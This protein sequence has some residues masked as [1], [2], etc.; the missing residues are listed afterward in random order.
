MCEATTLPYRLQTERQLG[1]DGL[2]VA[3]DENSG[4][5][6]LQE[7]WV[8]GLQVRCEVTASVFVLELGHILAAATGRDREVCSRDGRGSR[9]VAEP[10]GEV[11]IVIDSAL[12]KGLI[13]HVR[14]GQSR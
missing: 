5:T 9:P 8:V 12:E 1:R 11:S 10:C 2:E 7:G 3:A 13:I 14:Q 4:E 6:A